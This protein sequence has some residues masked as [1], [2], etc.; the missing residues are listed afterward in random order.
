[1]ENTKKNP[2]RIKDIDLTV[3]VDPSGYPLDEL[4]EIAFVGRSNVGKSSMVNT[5]LGRKMAKVSQNPGKTRTINFYKINN[6]FTVVDLPGYGFAKAPKNEVHKWGQMIETYLTD[7]IQLKAIALLLDIRHE[8]SKDDIQMYEWLTHYEYEVIII[9][10]KLDKIK[11]S[12]IQK[13]IKMLK[14]GI[15]N[16]DA[17]VIPFSSLDKIGVDPLW[18]AITERTLPHVQTEETE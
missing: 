18:D 2:L 11:R 12:Q 5:L 16:K 9:A 1:M 17:V 13:H 4:G 15:N 8:P 3:A 6:A 7:R 14:T 10:T